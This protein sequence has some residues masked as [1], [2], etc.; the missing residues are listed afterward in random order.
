MKV[1]D[2]KKIINELEI[3]GKTAIYESMDKA[4]FVYVLLKNYKPLYIG[5]TEDLNSRILSHNKDK[6]FDKVIVSGVYKN[7]STALFHEKTLID[8]GSEFFN[9]LNKTG[10]Y[11]NVLTIK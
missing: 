8:F 10:G 3:D 1:K 6:D 7:R 9:L 4:Y 11:R 2:L 5:C